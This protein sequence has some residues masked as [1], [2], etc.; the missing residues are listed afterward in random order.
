MQSKIKISNYFAC[1]QQLKLQF[2]QVKQLGSMQLQ[3]DHVHMKS[4]KFLSCVDHVVS[5]MTPVLHGKKS[6]VIGINKNVYDDL[7]AA[8]KKK[9]ISIV[10]VK[11]LKGRVRAR[12][13]R[14]DH[15]HSPPPAAS[16]AS[17]ARLQFMAARAARL[18]HPSGSG[19]MEGQDRG[20]SAVV[21]R[22]WRLEGVRARWSTAWWRVARG[23]ASRRRRE[24]CGED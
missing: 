2:E 4:I 10:L 11:E 16:S 22:C 12:E 1:V 5:R 20:G 23:W 17:A 6:G 24:L 21:E 14:D 9:N 8:Q 3:S 13:A 7:C 15:G 19:E 18:P